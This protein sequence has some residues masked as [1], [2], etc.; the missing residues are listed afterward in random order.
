MINHHRSRFPAPG[1]EHKLLQTQTPL[2]QSLTL[3]DDNSDYV[4]V[5]RHVALILVHNYQS[6]PADNG[7]PSQ[8]G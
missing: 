1:T 7:H 6:I 4:D 5:A 8:L 2:C 3:I